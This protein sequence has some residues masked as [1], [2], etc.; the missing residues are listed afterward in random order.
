MQINKERVGN[1]TLQAEGGYRDI[2]MLEECD[3]AVQRLCEVC[4]WTEELGGLLNPASAKR[5]YTGKEP[6][7]KSSSTRQYHTPAASKTSTTQPSG[8]GHQHPF[9]K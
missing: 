6:K 2:A 8:N 9:R 4:S 5:Q 1:F 7:L 3:L